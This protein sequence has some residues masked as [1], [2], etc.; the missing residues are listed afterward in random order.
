MLWRDVATLVKV[1]TT[2]DADGY[3]VETESRREVFVDAQSVRRSEFY[4]ARQSGT[5]IA[6][7]FLIRAADYER[8]SRIEY[9][10]PEDEDVTTYSVVRSYT[11]AGE[12]IE[13]NCSIESSPG[14]VVRKGMQ[15]A[16]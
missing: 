4:A 14:S 16:K 12:I 11:K 5:A 3:T 9:K 2:K 6:I 8:E 7:V 1:E 13:L 15:N 10:H